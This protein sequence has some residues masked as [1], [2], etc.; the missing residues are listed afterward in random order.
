M[1]YFGRFRKKIKMKIHEIIETLNR[2]SFN[3]ENDDY[4]DIKRKEDETGEYT[5]TLD[6]TVKL[7]RKLSEVME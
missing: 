5:H 3:I 2:L 4:E 7:L 6:V 1:S